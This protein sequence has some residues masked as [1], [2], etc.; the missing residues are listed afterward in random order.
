MVFIIKEVHIK[1]KSNM[2]RDNGKKLLLQYFEEKFPTMYIMVGCLN[3]DG[4]FSIVW[5][6][7]IDISDNI[8]EINAQDKEL[9]LALSVF[10][11]INPNIIYKICS[12]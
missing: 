5:E 12:V 9:L 6:D 1:L 4:Y 7:I 8:E 3:R 11:H 2:T 10:S